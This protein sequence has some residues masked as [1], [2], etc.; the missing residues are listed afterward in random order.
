MD[1]T[2]AIIKLRSVT[3]SQGTREAANGPEYLL[4]KR[5]GQ[6]PLDDW[7]GIRDERWLRAHP[8]FC[9]RW[10]V[11]LSIIAG[12]APTVRVWYCSTAITIEE[13]GN[14]GNHHTT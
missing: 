2:E 3:I 5:Q 8:S 4:L 12:A 11:D 1:F 14:G 6:W 9:A 7:G 13:N 10:G